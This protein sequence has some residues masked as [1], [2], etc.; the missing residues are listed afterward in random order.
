M[1]KTNKEKLKEWALLEIKT[2]TPFIKLL[3]DKKLKKFQKSLI[4]HTPKELYSTVT[5]ATWHIINCMLKVANFDKFHQPLYIFADPSLNQFQ[6]HL[7]LS[8]E[9]PNFVRIIDETLVKVPLEWVWC[10]SFSLFLL[11][12]LILLCKNKRCWRIQLLQLYYKLL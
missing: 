11:L 1:S 5:Q 9:S 2:A 12:F 8:I 4:A 6:K 7:V 10:K 3:S